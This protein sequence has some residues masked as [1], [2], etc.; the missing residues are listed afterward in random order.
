MAYFD[1]SLALVVPVLISRV[2]TLKDTSLKL[3]L[4]FLYQV[5][6]DNQAF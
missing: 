6:Q 3:Q 4:F 1:F 2:Q 5:V